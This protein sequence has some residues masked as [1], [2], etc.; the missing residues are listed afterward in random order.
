MNTITC[1]ANAI[2]QDVSGFSVEQIRA[3]MADA[4]NVSAG[5]EAYVRGRRAGGEYRLRF[6]DD[7]VFVRTCGSKGADEARKCFEGSHGGQTRKFLSHLEKRGQIGG[8]A[9]QLFRV[10]K[11]STRAKVYRGGIDH[12]DGGM[13]SFRDLAYDKKDECIETLCEMLTADSCGMEWGW[14]YD[15]KNPIAPEVLYVETPNG[16]V[17]FH[18]TERYEGPDF[19]GEWD[20]SHSSGERIIQFCQDVFDGGQDGG[21]QKQ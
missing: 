3:A 7:L 2:R 5:V 16:Q 10:Q 17:S 14:K 9:A 4:L 1:T 15:P 12:H 13:T 11:A 19:P 20:K 6:N 8:L 21:I 18:S